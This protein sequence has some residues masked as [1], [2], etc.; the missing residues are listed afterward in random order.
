MEFVLKP[1]S[2]YTYPESKLKDY[3]CYSIGKYFEIHTNGDISLCCYSW[4]PK[5]FGNV[6]TDSAE[7]IYNNLER[8]KALW[9]MDRGFFVHC[10]DRCPY[11]SSLL[12]GDSHDSSPIVHN[13]IF[14]FEKETQPI[15]VNFSYDQS[16]NLQCPSCR[17]DLILHKLGHNTTLEQIHNNTKQF[18]QYL[19]DKGHTVILKITGSGDSFASPLYWEYLKELN[20]NA[21]KNIILKLQTNGI[22]CTKAKLNEIKNLWNNIETLNISIDAASEKTYNIVRKN[23][24]FRK[25]KTNLQNLNNLISQK[26]FKNLRLFITNFTVQKANYKELI[27]FVKWQL[28]YDQVNS[29]FLGLVDRWGHIDYF[30]FEENFNLNDSEKLE[31][32]DMLNDPI[33]KNNK[34]TLGNLNSLKDKNESLLQNNRYQ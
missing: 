34:I 20:K 2:Y 14:G 16:C 30:N 24:N 11:I 17:D 8:R 22:L 5:F 15:V 31:L 29:I 12:N 13:S 23:G 1:E 19:I 9:Y 32:K 26:N 27:D 4:L 6:L 10:N 18:V 25:L 7:Q 21:N 3:G 33:F 28:T